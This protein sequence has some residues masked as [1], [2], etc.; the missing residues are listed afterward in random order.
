MNNIGPSIDSW[1]TPVEISSQP[2]KNA[3]TEVLWNRLHKKLCNNFREAVEKA[4][5]S[6]LARSKLWFILSKAFERMIRMAAISFPLL[7]FFLLE[8]LGL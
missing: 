5:A 4:Y 3:F 2:L 7:R 6:S 8:W 1:G